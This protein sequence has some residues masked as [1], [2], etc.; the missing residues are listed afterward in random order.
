MTK[1]KK[2]IKN[3]KLSLFILLILIFIF[4]Y[5]CYR[6][7]MPDFY[8]DRDAANLYINS[9]S[10]VTQSQLFALYG[11]KSYFLHN[12]LL[13]IFTFYFVLF[14]FS[15][16]FKIQSYNQFYNIKILSNKFFLYI[17]LNIAYPFWMYFTQKM[18]IVEM[19]KYVYP[20][21]ADNLYIAT[22]GTYF[23]LFIIGV[24]YYP[25]V[26]IFNFIVHDTKFV[27]KLTIIIYKSL[28]VLMLL[29][30]VSNMSYQYIFDYYFLYII[31]ILYLL[32]VLNT[33]NYL[34]CKSKRLLAEYNTTTRNTN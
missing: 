22:F 8:I 5:V 1:I 11:N 15:F 28:F 7:K 4:I 12:G 16:L 34:T 21:Q 32:I 26:N 14:I 24:V 27:N 25:L 33:I 2:Y 10:D 23:L 6:F 13:H 3:P 9:A 17:Y 30:I 18:N 31:E 20:A 19:E 29:Y